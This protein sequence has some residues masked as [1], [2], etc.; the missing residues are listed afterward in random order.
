MT[1]TYHTFELRLRPTAKKLT[2]DVRC[3]S[4]LRENSEIEFTNGNFLSTSINL[5]NKSA[6]DGCRDKTIKKT[7]LRA[8]RARTFSRGL[9]QR[10]QFELNPTTSGLALTSEFPCAPQTGA[11]GQQP[12]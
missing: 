5:E 6:G 12:T 2:M 4:W 10:R 11:M 8:L 9:G 3:G 7:I 1:T